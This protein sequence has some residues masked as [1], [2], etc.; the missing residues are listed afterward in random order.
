MS[1]DYFIEVNLEILII[2][3]LR[4]WWTQLIYDALPAL[5]SAG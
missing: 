2:E 3:N 1:G 4:K 5:S